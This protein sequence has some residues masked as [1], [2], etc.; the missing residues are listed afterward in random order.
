MSEG[1]GLISGAIANQN[2]FATG[3]FE[4]PDA[5]KPR[6]FVVHTRSR[7]EKSASE[8]LRRKDIETFLP[9]YHSTRRWQNGDHEVHLPLFPG[10]T[11]VRMA[12]R[13]RLEVLKVPGV[14][15]LVG[16]RHTAVPLDDAEVEGLRQALAAGVSVAPHPYLIVGRRV[17]ITAGPL[18]GREGI[19]VRR[20]GALRMVLSIDLIQRS[21]LV[22][23]DASELEPAY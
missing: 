22:D 11:F 15:R 3:E 2:L 12:L 6:W 17:R 19:L 13:D 9:L 5:C 7:H 10:Y 18:T 4:L 20:R 16:V 23:L 14:V 8:L 1:T 21:V